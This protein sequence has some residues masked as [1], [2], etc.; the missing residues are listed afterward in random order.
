MVPLELDYVTKRFA[1]DRPPATDRLS[2]T[3]E[4]GR[5]FALPFDP[6]ETGDAVIIKRYFRGSETLCC[7]GLPSGLHVHSSPS[8]A[9]LP[10]GLRVRPRV[11][12]LHV[13]TFPAP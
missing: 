7:L 5:I 10:L 3:L 9:T 12:V 11:H 6:D 2:L 1:A 8:S 13:V 4:S